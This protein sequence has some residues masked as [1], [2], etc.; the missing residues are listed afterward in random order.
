MYVT[1]PMSKKPQ[2][3]FCLVKI[4]CLACL[5]LANPPL[6]AVTVPVVTG[7][8]GYPIDQ[9]GDEG[10]DVK[11]LGSKVNDLPVGETGNDTNEARVWL[12]FV[13][14][15]T[16]REAALEPGTSITL[17]IFLSGKSAV[18]GLTASIHGAGYRSAYRVN[19]SDYATLT[20]E[21]I[22][23]ALNE[24]TATGILTY[25]V[26]AFVQEEAARP[27]TA[28]IGFGF[29]IRLEDENALPNSD[30]QRNAFLIGS[31]NRDPAEAA[32][33]II[34]QTPRANN[35][36]DPSPPDPAAVRVLILGNSILHNSPLPDIG[37]AGNWGMAASEESKDFAHLLMERIETT[38]KRPVIF[39]LHNIAFWENTW[40]SI[41][42]DI[43]IVTYARDFNP[44]III[45]CISENT[46]LTD[47]NVSPYKEKYRDMIHIMAAGDDGEGQA[48]VIV[49][50]SFWSINNNT[51]LALSEVAAEE[52][53]P[54]VRC[55]ML[56]DIPENQAWEADYYL[57]PEPVD[58]SV[59]NHPSDAGMQAIADKIWNEA[60]QQLLEEKYVPSD[61][62]SGYF[63]WDSIFSPIDDLWRIGPDD[64]FDGDGKS[65]FAEYVFYSDP[66]SKE[67]RSQ[68]VITHSTDRLTLS[69]GAR[70]N[71]AELNYIIEWSEDLSQWNA[72]DL[73]YADGI[74]NLDPPDSPLQVVGSPTGEGWTLTVS[75][76][77]SLGTGI[78]IFL[79]V[80]ANGNS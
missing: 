31:S 13:L 52:G 53:Y 9:N 2:P 23:Y 35:P 56:S 63:N 65:N 68:P 12:P 8:D 66:T 5:V 75:Q 64:D 50:G 60:L 58:A 3:L 14:S 6:G 79:R 15:E 73:I 33:L 78:P 72:L 74:W 25:D 16:E 34:E 48:D 44:H 61:S 47:A 67:S 18:H 21:L 42:H 80:S 29:L 4:T 39:K 46:G 41:R 70:E 49:R 57:G 37:W 28:G 26:T 77:Q 43:P 76:K 59:L 32:Q 20:K 40:S 62:T 11:I 19:Q 24:K 36:E 7:Y 69:F 22:P 10:G 1:L 27:N 54:Y 51:D 30:G 71:D 17:Q 45:S 55:D 38:I